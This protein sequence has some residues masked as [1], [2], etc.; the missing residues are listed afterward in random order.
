MLLAD[1]GE[2]PAEMV[3]IVSYDLM[4]LD[5]D[6]PDISDLDLLRFLSRRKV[7]C[8]ILLLSNSGDTESGF[9]G[10]EDGAD[11]VIQKSLRDPELIARCHALMRR[12]RGNGR[13]RMQ[14]RKLQLDL[15]NTCAEVSGRP[16]RRTSKEYQALE[17]LATRRGLP[18][19]MAKPNSRIADRVVCKLRRK[20]RKAT[21]G[22]TYIKTIW[23]VGYVM[24][25]E[26]A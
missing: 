14:I 19:R 12:S 21:G 1:R 8:P 16:L 17:L 20:L 10:F 18:L 26:D 7:S 2:D 24:Q 6:L 13:P 3:S 23:G 25:E 4:I 11:D 5:S 9:R 22:P 15:A